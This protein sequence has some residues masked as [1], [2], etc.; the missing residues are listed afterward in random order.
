MTGMRRFTVLLLAALILMASAGLAE[1]FAGSV[2]EVEEAAKSVLLVRVYN[3]KDVLIATGS[4]FVA[5]DSRTLVT[6][7]HVMEDAAWMMA[8]TDDGKEFRVTK[9]IAAN[10]DKD[11][12]LL[13]FELPTTITPLTLS[14]STEELHRAQPVVAIG[15]P[16]GVKNTVSMGNI[17]AIYEEDEVPYIQFTAPISP[18]SSGG[19]LFDDSGKVIG[20]TSATYIGGQ[21]MNLAIDIAEVLTL[22]AEAGNDERRTF[23]EYRDSM[24]LNATPTPKPTLGPPW[25]VDTTAAPNGVMLS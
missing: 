9:V 10:R 13:E 21:N 3:E 7:Y 15:S 25:Y 17:S 24:K 4:G 6:N 22:Y 2:A 1:S 8:A 18:G 11:I 23:K 20:I 19:A 5:F 14:E 16:I 12:A